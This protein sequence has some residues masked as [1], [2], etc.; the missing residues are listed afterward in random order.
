V[1]LF[2]GMAGT[3][4]RRLNDQLPQEVKDD[5][6]PRK[7]LPSF[8][9]PAIC[10]AAFAILLYAIVFNGHDIVRD[11][12]FMEGFLGRMIPFSICGYLA[13]IT[14]F[15]VYV[16]L[17]ERLDDLNA[18]SVEL[19]AAEQKAFVAAHAALG[20]V[21]PAP[22]TPPDT[23]S[24]YQ[25][26]FNKIKIVF[27]GAFS[28]TAAILSLFVLWVGSL[29]NGVNSEQ[30]MRVYAQY[31]GKPFLSYDLVYLIGLMHTIL[32]LIFY[33]PAQLKFSAMDLNKNAPDGTQTS[34]KWLGGL[35]QTLGS[36]LVTASPLI[37][38][39]IQSI[40]SGVSK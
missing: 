5:F 22:P 36:V 32:L 15:S 8:I 1:P 29:F 14:C 37:A 26:A 23:P 6:K 35:I 13:A 38:S 27:M 18:Q 31:A 21:A 28:A 7:F 17:A 16:F 20:V 40:V 12:Y 11:Y 3:L 39:L 19:K 25:D 4:R 24:P 30:A 2:I 9:T 10:T 34:G 33:I